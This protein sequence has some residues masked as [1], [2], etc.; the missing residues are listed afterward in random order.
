MSKQ[1]GIFDEPK[2]EAVKLYCPRCGDVY[3]TVSPY[4][5][6]RER[7]VSGLKMKSVRAYSH[8]LVLL[9]KDGNSFNP[10]TQEFQRFVRNSM[11]RLIV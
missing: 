5:G 2:K 8:E 7:G 4:G 1:V 3:N 9:G 6:E 10:R 11:K